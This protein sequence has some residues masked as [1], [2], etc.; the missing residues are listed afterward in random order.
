MARKAS[1]RSC[2]SRG[3]YFTHFEGRRLKLSEGPDDAPKGAI[4][5]AALRVFS[6][7]MQVSN[8]DEADQGNAVRGVVDMHLGGEAVRGQADWGNEAD[9]RGR[10]ACPEGE[11]P[12]GQRSP[13]LRSRR[14]SRWQRLQVA[15]AA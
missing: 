14:P 13:P 10:W 1:V 4:C 7:M 11:V 8:S 3:A 2:K 9:P 5:L 12:C 6:E 15:G